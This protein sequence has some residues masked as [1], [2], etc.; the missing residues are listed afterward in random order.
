LDVTVIG[1]PPIFSSATLV[2]VTRFLTLPPSVSGPPPPALP[3]LLLP[4]QAAI[5]KLAAQHRA[6][7]LRRLESIALDSTWFMAEA[8]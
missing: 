5:S 3:S 4:P 8:S 2:P 7:Q 1:S 6:A